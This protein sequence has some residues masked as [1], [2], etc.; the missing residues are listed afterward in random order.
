[1]AGIIV[2]LVWLWLINL[3]LLIGVAVNAE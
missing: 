3:A 2:F 1:V